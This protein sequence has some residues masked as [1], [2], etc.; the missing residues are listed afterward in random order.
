MKAHPDS[1]DSHL[2]VDEVAAYL[3]AAAEPAERAQIEA[4]LA[5]CR[6]CRDELVVV[7]EASRRLPS[8]RP[9]RVRWAIAGTAAAAA[10]IALV[11]LSP[12]L[13]SPT[14]PRLLRDVGGAD[15]AGAVTAMEV[16]APEAAENPSTRAVSFVWRAA[17]PDAQYRLM[18]TTT[19]GD[20]VWTTTTNDTSVALPGAVIL[21]PDA[22]YFWWV[23]GLLPDGGTATTGVRG[24]RTGR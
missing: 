3:D 21:E 11:L 20:P 10:A 5:D 9:V 14:G 7:A 2:T 15:P 19:E 4:H 6:P 22:E 8:R 13:D 23:D 1:T 12:V 24:F 18:L 17:G 16:V